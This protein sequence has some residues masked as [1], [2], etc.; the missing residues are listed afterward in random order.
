ME[1]QDKFAKLWKNA[2]DY[3]A[4]TGFKIKLAYFI[5]LMFILALIALILSLGLVVLLALDSATRIVLPVA[6]FIAMLSM[7]TG[8]PSYIRT[9]R[10]DR[11][12]A[13]LPDVLNHIS[14]VL[15]AGGT[16]ESALEEVSQ[17]DYG[18]ISP[19]IAQGL[20]QLREGRSIDEV[21]DEMAV[22]SGSKLFRRIARITIDSRK[23]GA[24]L[25]E[26]LEAIADDSK[27][28]MR[29]RRERVSRTTMHVAFLYTTSLALVPFIFGFTLSIVKFIGAGMAQAGTQTA[30]DFGNFD[31]LLIAFLVVLVIIA[32]VAIGVVSEGR[33]T[34]NFVYVPFFILICLLVYHLGGYLGVAI[35]SGG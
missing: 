13:A 2:E 22:K 3:Y 9:R 4:G 28:M 17:S 11:I 7:I 29:I 35:I 27:E 14:A 34:K 30:M 5:A 20:Q 23:A 32:N 15:R 25:A 33:T 31:A 12:E 1:E 18:P 16:V 19:H 6:A 26:V 24:G 10:V 8:I 21:L